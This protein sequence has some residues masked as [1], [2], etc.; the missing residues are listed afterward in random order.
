MLVLS[1][2]Q[3]LATCVHSV[4][5][6]LRDYRTSNAMCVSAVPPFT[7]E[8]IRSVLWQHIKGGKPPSG[9]TFQRKMD[10]RI[11]GYDRGYFQQRVSSSLEFDYIPRAFFDLL[12][13]IK[14]VV[15]VDRLISQ[16]ML[17]DPT[18]VDRR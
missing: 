1:P 11:S 6:A 13:Q 15:Y 12:L 18:C 8:D 3:E 4:I 7:Y 14:D 10:P 5:L 9:I 17:S 16:P 2:T